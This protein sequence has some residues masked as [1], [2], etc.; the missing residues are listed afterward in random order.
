M[1][2]VD[3][4]GI[5]IGVSNTM[6]YHFLGL[7]SIFDFDILQFLIMSF[8]AIVVLRVVTH[9]G[10]SLSH[11]IDIPR[12]MYDRFES[13]IHAEHAKDVSEDKSKE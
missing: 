13:R 5:V 1:T 12:N 11:S 3:Y 8:A 2:L 6:F 9:A 4:L 10:S 7:Y